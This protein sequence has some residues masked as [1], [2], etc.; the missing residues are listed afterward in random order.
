[1]GITLDNTDIRL[2]GGNI[3]KILEKLMKYTQSKSPQ[4]MIKI[5]AAVAL[6]IIATK[7]LLVAESF[8]GNLHEEV[9]EALKSLSK[10]RLIRVQNTANEALR[11]WYKLK[12][13]LDKIETK[14]KKRD[15]VEF[16]PDD[17][18]KMRTGMDVN[19]AGEED[20]SKLAENI[21]ALTEKKLD[22]E[23]HEIGSSNV[24]VMDRYRKTLKKKS[25]VGKYFLCSI[26]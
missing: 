23:D 1:M 16:S 19:E 9:I 14:K 6:N 10:D 15:I 11:V 3:H 25:G 7:L 8:I 20:P 5:E 13:E 22:K 18:I 17:I 21:Q 24:Y 26:K 2:S 4:Y 12:E